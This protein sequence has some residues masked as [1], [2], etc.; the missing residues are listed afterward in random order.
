M[1]LIEILFWI[2][3]VI[4]LVLLYKISTTAFWI[5]LIIGILWAVYRMVNMPTVQRFDAPQ[6]NDGL[7]TSPIQSNDDADGCG[8]D[9]HGQPIPCNSCYYADNGYCWICMQYDGGCGL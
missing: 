9:E 8:P 7:Y 3:L 2:L 4:L 6:I 5:V 1:N